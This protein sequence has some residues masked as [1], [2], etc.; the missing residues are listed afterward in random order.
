MEKLTVETMEKSLNRTN[1][2]TQRSI[3]ENSEMSIDEQREQLRKRLNIS[4]LE[5]TFA[6][7]KP[8]KEQVNAEV[9]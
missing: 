6:N 2:P 7:F 8:V 5:N 4:S 1:L 3:S 9:V